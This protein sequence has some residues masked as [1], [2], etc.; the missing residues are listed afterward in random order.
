MRLFVYDTGA[1]F[2]FYG[3]G[4]VVNPENPEAKYQ[5]GFNLTLVGSKPGK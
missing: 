1:I 5:I 2:W 4:K 3:N